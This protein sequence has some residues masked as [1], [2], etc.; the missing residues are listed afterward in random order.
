MLPPRFLVFLEKAR[1]SYKIAFFQDEYRYCRQRFEFINHYELD[2]VY[3][4]VEPQHFSEVYIKY[5]NIPQL[6]YNLPGYVDDNLIA[7][8]RIMTKP[9]S[10]REI[11]IGYRGRH[12]PYYMGRGAREKT[13][14]GI[15][16]KKLTQGLGLKSDI[17]VDE[18]KRLYGNK[19]YEFLSN[20]RAFLGVEAGVTIFDTQDFVR[21]GYERLLAQKPDITFE[22]MSEQLLEPWED[23]IFYRTISPRHF[24]AAAFRVCQ[25]LYEGKYSGILQPMIHYIPLKKDWSNF[26]EVM[27]RFKDASLRRE[28]TENAYQDLIASGRYSYQQFI[29]G[30]D[31]HLIKAGLKAK[32]TNEEKQQITEILERGN[33]PRWLWAKIRS[34][35]YLPFPGR[36]IVVRIVKRML[37]F[38]SRIK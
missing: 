8:A 19:W 3:T 36:R 10:E 5:T 11:D 31:N 34:L 30:F 17:E 25:I 14:I 32:V 22:D 20:S 33:T 1:N 12:H 24:E 29:A 2:C 4:L 15:E 7:L 38:F 13:R 21:I 37:V 27:H 16:F 35:P 18:N 26:D 6:V 23:N 28:L 9:N